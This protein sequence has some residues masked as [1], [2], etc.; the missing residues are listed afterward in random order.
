MKFSTV[1]ST[2]LS[3]LAVSISASPIGIPADTEPIER[4]SPHS[5]QHI[6]ARTLDPYA[7]AARAPTISK[8]KAYEAAEKVHK[9]LVVNDYYVFTIEWDLKSE[10][11]ADEKEEKDVYDLQQ[12][13]GYAHVAVLVGK[14]T[15][16]T[17]G[18]AG[19][20]TTTKD[21]DAVFIDQVVAEDDVT[22]MLRG[23]VKFLGTQ[24]GQALKYQ[25]ETTAKKGD[26]SNVKKIGQAYFDIKGHNVYSTETN[27]CGTFKDAILP[28]L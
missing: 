8:T 7:L 5:F 25:K 24:K 23:P 1:L 28:Q 17:T 3:S 19:A 15:E 9:N 13:L 2:L 12:S 14:V 6:A 16:K 4:H 26:A 18:K 11:M 10:A 21:F 22:A 20:K 27:H